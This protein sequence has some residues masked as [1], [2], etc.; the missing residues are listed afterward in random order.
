L[1]SVL[2]LGRIGPRLSIEIDISRK[3][4]WDYGGSKT[5]EK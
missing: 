4:R 1:T 5:K 3:D 2:G